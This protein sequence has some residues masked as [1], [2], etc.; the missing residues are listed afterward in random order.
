MSC[1]KACQAKGRFSSSLNLNKSLR[2]CCLYRNIHVHKVKCITY[3]SDQR[4]RAGSRKA[5]TL[6]C[7]HTVPKEL[8]Q[9]GME[10]N[11]EPAPSAHCQLPKPSLKDAANWN[12]VLL[13]GQFISL[14]FFFFFPFFSTQFMN[15][16]TI[17]EW[18]HF[19]FK[20]P[21]E[22]LSNQVRSQLLG[23]PCC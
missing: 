7:F 8:W 2:L 15:C 6:L 3:R 20:W 9:A 14:S 4:K 10:S 16:I 21:T 23:S 11:Q 5:L 13:P 22:L 12:R 1:R 17:T 18:S 19:L